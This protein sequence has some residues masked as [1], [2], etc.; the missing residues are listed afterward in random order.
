MKKQIFT[1][2][3]AAACGLMSCSKGSTTKNAGCKLVSVTDGFKL[4]S[5]SMYTFTYSINYDNQGRPSVINGNS[6]F[7]K[8]FRYGNG[9]L[10]T[11]EFDNNSLLR[12][13]SVMIDAQNHVTAVYHTDL[14]SSSSDTTIFTYN[15]DGTLATSYDKGLGLYTTCQWQNGDLVSSASSPAISNVNYFFDQ[16]RLYQNGD[17]FKWS[18][19]ESFGIGTTVKPKHFSLGSSNGAITNFNTDS[20][21]NV[22]SYTVGQGSSNATDYTFA[23]ECK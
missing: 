22:I 18:D 21:G 12:T 11:Q 6:G 8:K 14:L 16:T 15:T 3:A 19:M 1:L 23:Y 2:L 17:M 13:D 10:T 9:Y 5:G 7:S 20:L 4:S